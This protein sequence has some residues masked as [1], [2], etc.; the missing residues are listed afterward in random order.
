MAEEGEGRA[1]TAP[2][3]VGRGERCL[4]RR[5]LRRLT[6]IPEH[7]IKHGTR[8]FTVYAPGQS[9]DMRARLQSMME[10]PP[11]AM[12]QED[13][14]EPIVEE[15]ANERRKK[16]LTMSNLK[17]VF[18]ALDLRDDGYIDTE[19]LYEAQ[20]KIGGRLSRSEVEDIIWEVDDDMDGRLSM[21]DY[22]TTYR[23]TQTDEFGFEPKR[24]FSI[25]EFLLMDRDCSGEITVDEAMTTLF[26]RQG[27]NNLG[28]V[29]KEFFRAVG[30]GEGEEPPPGATI[31]FRTY[32]RRIGCAKPRVPNML[33]LRRTFSTHLRVSEGK[34]EAP[35]LR[36]SSSYPT[37]P[38]VLQPVPPQSQS[39]GK[40][41]HRGRPATSGG[42]T[43]VRLVAEWGGKES[44]SSRPKSV[45]S[46][47]RRSHSGSRSAGAML[48]Y[49]L[50]PHSYPPDSGGRGVR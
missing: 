1:Q 45:L 42:H 4:T 15:S 28:D 43:P 25:V 9:G 44:P 35:K 40:A 3:R 37:L 24:F 16:F 7:K 50:M 19:E 22:L 18:S 11:K 20:K 23:R 21:N 47:M 2:A 46:G 17:R 41:S 34:G 10:P 13:E 39:H 6:K 8:Q 26:E 12:K 33:D 30:V 5:T 49:L 14:D 36:P 29:T 38:R 31:T 32:Y 27:A 48:L